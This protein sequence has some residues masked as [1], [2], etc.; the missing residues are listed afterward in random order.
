MEAITFY[1]VLKDRG[2]VVA[3]TTFSYEIDCYEPFRDVVHNW[4][5]KCKKTSLV[6]CEMGTGRE[7][8]DVQKT[9]TMEKALID[10]LCSERYRCYFTETFDLRIKV[11]D[12]DYLQHML[13]FLTPLLVR[14]P[15]YIAISCSFDRSVRTQE[16]HVYFLEAKFRLIDRQRTL[17]H[18][19]SVETKLEALFQ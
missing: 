13:Y 9:R 15:L 1:S 7:G 3:W 4:V 19:P 11:K 8:A 14:L 2:S 12:N 6:V 10:G 5:R 16:S 17:V 18:S